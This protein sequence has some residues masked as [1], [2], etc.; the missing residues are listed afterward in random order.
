V[1]QFVD[2]GRI[3]W[4]TALQGLVTYVD[5]APGYGTLSTPLVNGTPYSTLPLQ[6]ALPA[7][8]AG[9]QAIYITDGVNIDTATVVGGGATAGDTS[10]SVMGYTAAFDFADT[11]TTVTPVP[12]ET[13]T[14]LYNGAGGSVVRIAAN[15]GAAGISPGE[16]LLS[17]YFD[18]SQPTAVYVQ[19]GYFG[20][21][22]ATSTPGSGTFIGEDTQY[23]GHTLNADSA[24]PQLDVNLITL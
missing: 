18:G 7:N 23:W 4:A 12:A 8:I 15:T 6:A 14:A 11:S 19:V 1:P 3:L 13:D 22:S 10:I 24:A 2:A 5:F 9:G 20:G 21:P 16:S 17:A